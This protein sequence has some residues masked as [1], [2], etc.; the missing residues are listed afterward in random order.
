VVPMALA[1]AGWS[2]TERPQLLVSSDGTLVGLMGQEGRALSVPKGGGFIAENWLQDDGDLAAQEVAAARA[3]F[4]GPATARRFEV[5]GW[6]A[7]ALRG[8]GAAAAFAEACRSADLVILPSGVKPE[9][10]PA[11]G[12]VVIGREVLD[13]TGALAVSIRPD[14]L[15]LQPSRFGARIW[16]TNRPALQQLRIE[17]P[18]ASVAA[19]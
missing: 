9:T 1:F 4:E 5:A 3:G 13:A 15:D 16:M 10:N 2:M 19:N 8:K 11:G 12:C 6:R 7:V 18:K 14:H 17:K